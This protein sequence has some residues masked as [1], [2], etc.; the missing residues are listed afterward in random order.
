MFEEYEQMLINKSRLKIEKVI[1]DKGIENIA[2]S[3]SGGKDSTVLK[4]LVESIDSSIISVFC[5]TGVEYKSIVDFVNTFDDVKIVEPRI[6]FP[7]VIQKYGFPVVSKEQSRYISDVNN[8]KV[9]QRMK[10]IRLGK[11]NFSISKKWR[12]LLYTDIKISDK[13]C[14]HLKKA[15]LKK[16]GFYYF[17]GER[18]LESNLRKQR[19]HTCILPNKCVPLRLW[20]DELIEK[21]IKYYN[22]KICDIYKHESRTG[23][24]FCLYGIQCEKRPNRIDRLKFIEPKSYKFAEKIGIVDLMGKILNHNKL[25]QISIFDIDMKLL[26]L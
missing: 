7:Q 22:I 11:G 15:P 24:K 18:I 16:L 4:H 25:N 13:C 20:T 26:K 8:S 9:C 17:T 1:E 23:C 3:F 2:V 6:R 14:Y 10:D 5:N 19:Y 12:W 21:Y